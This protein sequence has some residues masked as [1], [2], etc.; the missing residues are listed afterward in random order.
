MA[1]LSFLHFLRVLGG[2][3]CFFEHVFI[4][5]EIFMQSI[6]LNS[7]LRDTVVNDDLRYVEWSNELQF[8]AWAPRILTTASFD[9]LKNASQL[10]A[11]KFDIERAPDLLDSIDAQILQAR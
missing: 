10:F 7:P 5:D 3:T 8:P 4:A 1:F 6:L 11:R 2:T 9:A